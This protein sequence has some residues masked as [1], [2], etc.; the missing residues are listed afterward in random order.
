MP[1]NLVKRFPLQDA[2]VIGFQVGSL[3]IP[4]VSPRKPQELQAMQRDSE[5]DVGQGEGLPTQ[6]GL[7]TLF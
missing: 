5:R 3:S 1:Q 4:P 6:P 7:A 2:L